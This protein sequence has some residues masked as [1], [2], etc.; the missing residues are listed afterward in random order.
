[1]ESFPDFNKLWGHMHNVTLYAGVTYRVEIENR[2]DVSRFEGK[3]YIYISEVNVLGGK[4]RFLG[5]F[6]LVMAGILVLM[7][8][9]FVFLYFTRVYGKDIYSTDD[10]TW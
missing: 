2:F 6:F 10:L 5:I 3:K 9:I 7:M 8:I 1:M 4:S